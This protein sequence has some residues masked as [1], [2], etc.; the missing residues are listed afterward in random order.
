VLQDREEALAATTD[1]RATYE[2]AGFGPA[3]G[4]VL[5]L[6]M[7]KGP[8]LGQNIVGTTHHELDFDALRAGSTRI[9]IGAGAGAE[10]EGELA[11]RAA[12]AVAE[13]LGIQAVVFPSH[14]GGFVGGRVALERRARRVYSHLREVLAER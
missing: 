8:L 12:Y 4:K 13:R 2:R 11:N 14:H 7:L 10:S 5:A 9:V 6:T 3:M 1:I